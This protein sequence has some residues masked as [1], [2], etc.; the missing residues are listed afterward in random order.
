MDALTLLLCALATWRIS[1]LLVNESGP[2]D[3]FGRLRGFAVLKLGA[4]GVFSC[5]WCMSVWVSGAVA[6]L[7]ATAPGVTFW[8]TLVLSQ[9]ALAISWDM[10]LKG[11]KNHGD[12]ET[13]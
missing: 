3:M 9:S 6:L 13:P 10:L 2:F 12:S 1:S 11:L 5:I 8:V 7:Y 4:D